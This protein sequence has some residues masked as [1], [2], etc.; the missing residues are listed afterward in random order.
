M[1][2][3]HVYELLTRHV[4]CVHVEGVLSSYVFRE[5]Q[6]KDESGMLVFVEIE[7]VIVFFVNSKAEDGGIRKGIHGAAILFGGTA[8]AALAVD[9]SADAAHL[10]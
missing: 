10:Q 1:R 5:E 8:R 2:Q 9:E 3:K 6:I 4:C 7:L